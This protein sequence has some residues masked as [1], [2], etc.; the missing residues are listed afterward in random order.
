[1]ISIIDGPG[2]A[3]DSDLRWKNIDK[4]KYYHEMK[5]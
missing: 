4:F 5:L 2:I 3:G 1:M